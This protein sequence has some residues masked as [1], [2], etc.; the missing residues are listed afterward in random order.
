MSTKKRTIKIAISINDAF[1]GILAAATHDDAP[2]LS[3]KSVKLTPLAELN[4]KFGRSAMLESLPK[5]HTSDLDLAT[6][7]I[8]L[9]T[10]KSALILTD[11]E[12]QQI[13]LS[14]VHSDGG[15]NYPL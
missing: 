4:K 13:R 14:D 5:N 2:P 6:L 1:H 11:R 3:L 12:G 7:H 8:L 10:M 9:T 15:N